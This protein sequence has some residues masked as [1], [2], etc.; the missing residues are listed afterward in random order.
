M[1]RSLVSARVLKLRTIFYSKK[2]T[3][4]PCINQ[5]K[6]LIVKEKYDYILKF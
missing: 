6:C 1:Y 3:K 2:V 5:L 4:S